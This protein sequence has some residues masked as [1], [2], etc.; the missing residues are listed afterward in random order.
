[1]HGLLQALEAELRRLKLELKQTLEAYNS[2]CRE[3]VIAKQKTEV[4]I[5]ES[6]MAQ[7]LA[8]MEAQRRKIAEKELSKR[9]KRRKEH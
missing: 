7:W 4:A 3:A 2:A 8:D 1:M 6:Q 5:E 9:Q